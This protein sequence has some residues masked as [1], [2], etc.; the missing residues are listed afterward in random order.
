M[1]EQILNSRKKLL[2]NL[3]L[4]PHTKG[5]EEGGCGV[6]GFACTIP[7]GGKH[8]FE[9][10]IQMHNRGNGKGGGIAAVGLTAEQLGVSQKILED[11]Y[12]LQIALLDPE[13]QQEVEHTCIMPFLDVHKAEKNRTVEAFRD[14]EGLETKP[15]DVWRYFVRVKPN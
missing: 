1:I 2:K 12:L 5:E 8:I 9:P 7:V 3:P 6:T 4:L 10:S 14:I 11:D 15:P 13:A